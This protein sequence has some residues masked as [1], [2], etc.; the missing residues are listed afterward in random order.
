MVRL[1]LPILIGLVAL[2]SIEFS[3][4]MAWLL[5]QPTSIVLAGLASLSG[6]VLVLSKSVAN[7]VSPMERWC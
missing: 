7:Q 2:V 3:D 4:V 6:V 5:V 1:L